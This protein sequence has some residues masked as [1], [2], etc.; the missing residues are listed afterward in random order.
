[1]SLDLSAVLSAIPGTEVP[2]PGGTGT[3]SGHAAGE[4]FDKLTE[5]LI[6]K[7]YPN[8]TYRQ[9][10]LLNALFAKHPTASTAAARRQLLGPPALQLLLARGVSAM[11]SW[12]ASKQFEEKQND[13]ADIVVLPSAALDLNSG[14]VHLVDVKTYSRD[15]AGQ[16]P[17]I[18]S[19]LKL[20]MMCTLMID[21]NNF[22]SHDMTYLGIEWALHG[23]KLIAERAAAAQ[24]FREEPG[25]LYINW[26][27]ALQIQFHV[28]NLVQGFGGT[29][30]EWCK[31][32]LTMYVSSAEHR[33]GTMQTKFIDPFKR[34]L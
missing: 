4:P 12:T 2:R 29:V 30:E 22:D 21:A 20:A 23:T 33:V 10:A 11:G 26:A 13:T 32:F 3:M 1:M 9:F 8:S 17:N 5:A 27:A 14:P 16:P 6:F 31:A 34:Y 24:L 28:H 7:T 19:A 18:I 25:R 15:K